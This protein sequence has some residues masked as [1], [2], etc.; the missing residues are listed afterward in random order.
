MEEVYKRAIDEVDKLD[1]VQMEARRPEWAKGQGSGSG[2]GRLA[3]ALLTMMA[4]L[5]HDAATDYGAPT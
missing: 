4:T 2:P 3:V 1:A 5:R